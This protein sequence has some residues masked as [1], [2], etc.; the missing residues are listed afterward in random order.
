MSRYPTV[1]VTFERRYALPQFWSG[2]EREVII[3]LKEEFQRKIRTD[4]DA[5]SM[6]IMD[7]EYDLI[8]S[9]LKLVSFL[10]LYIYVYSGK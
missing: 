7:I 8:G 10:F 6:T 2:L 9:F 1:R 4:P 3:A 5:T